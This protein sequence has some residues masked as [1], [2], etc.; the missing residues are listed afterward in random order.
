MR[1][2]DAAVIGGGV[3]GCFTARNLCR[4]SI[5]SVLI[6]AKA[7]VCTGSSRANTAIVYAGYDN[8]P[9]SLKAEMSVRG[10]AAMD[11][12]CEELEVPFSRC[13]SLMVSFGAQADAVLQKK[14]RAGLAAGVPDLRLICGEEARERE[15]MLARGAT[16]AL[17]A[18]STGTVNPWQLGIAAY[19]N[20]AAN[21]CEMLLGSRVMQIKKSAYGY[22]LETETETLECRCVLNC[23]GLAADRVQ[24][25]LFPPSVRLTLDGADFLILDRDAGTTNHII[26]HES[27]EKGKGITAVPTTDGNLL[28]GPSRRPLHG[29]PFATMQEG[30][31]FLR[32]TT[33][34]VLPDVPLDRI[35]RSFASVRPNPQR[36]VLRDGEYVPDGSSIG[37]FCIER[38]APGFTSLIGIKTPGLTCADQLGRMLAEET[39]AFLGAEKNDA[40]SPQRAAIRQVRGLSFEQR[41]LLAEENP[42]YADMICRCEDISRGEIL[43]AIARGAR[44]PDAVKRRVGTAMGHCQGSRCS[45]AICELLER[46]GHGTR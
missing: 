7:D 17:Y 36:V 29:K 43:E 38:P 34:A 42:A 11:R 44:T 10:N 26:F 32:E 46:S 35:I 9:G 13:G 27:E 18:P 40:F 19:E 39:A 3:L 41:K 5:S 37:S 8:K 16:S 4:Y 25:L 22:I 21:G 15:P 33:A 6:E 14:L 1:R 20:A 31:A 23:A 45:R 2:F 12:L 30:I 28:L 24:E